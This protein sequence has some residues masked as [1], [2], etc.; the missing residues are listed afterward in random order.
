MHGQMMSNMIQDLKSGVGGVD[1]VAA[2]Q[3]PSNRL[4]RLRSGPIC[5]A[6]HLQISVHVNIRW[7]MRVMS[8]QN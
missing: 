3:A 2:V 7:C 4:S 8:R 1:W 5:D 6:K